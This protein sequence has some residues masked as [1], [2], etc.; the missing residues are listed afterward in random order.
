MRRIKSRK[1]N[2]NKKILQ[3]KSTSNLVKN[4][5][6]DLDENEISNVMKE[7]DL[8]TSSD[9]N[10]NKAS[11]TIVARKVKKS[12]TLKR[13]KTKGD[14]STSS[15]YPD[16]ND[17]MEDSD[18]DEP[19]I[20][21]RKKVIKKKSSNKNIPQNISDSDA[22]NKGDKT[23]KNKIK[24]KLNENTLSSLVPAISVKGSSDTTSS[25]RSK[26]KSTKK[27]IKSQANL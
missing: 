15:I 17:S 24:V 5:T 4:T 10:T 22:D 6:I 8:I 26:K 14:A 27:I 7:L 11:P 12:K 2:K 18:N 16:T 20:R 25:T 19:V 13:S 23:K 3:K 21:R 9:L 1:F